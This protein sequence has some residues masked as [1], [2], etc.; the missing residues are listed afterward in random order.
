MPLDRRITIKVSGRLQMQ[1]VPGPNWL[2]TGIVRGMV[3]LVELSC[4]YHAAVVYRVR[5]VSWLAEAS[6]GGVLVPD[7]A[8][9]LFCLSI[10]QIREDTDSGRRR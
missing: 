4:S 2:K 5:F 7:A 6:P 10:E 8:R 9:R 3:R 1:E